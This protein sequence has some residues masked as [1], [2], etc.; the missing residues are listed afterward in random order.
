MDSETALVWTRVKRTV[1]FSLGKLGL[2]ARIGKLSIRLLGHRLEWAGIDHVKQIAGMNDVAVAELD[3]VHEA[4]DAGA[5][6]NLL[7]CL[8]PPGEFVP[9]GDG[10]LG[11][12][13]HRNGRR[14]RRCLLRRL[15]AAPGQAQRGRQDQR[16]EAAE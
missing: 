10:T 12:L 13:C 6:L 1:E 3:A 2:G 7:D 8:E 14:R 11:W 4:A 15:V 16:P 5:N 9:V